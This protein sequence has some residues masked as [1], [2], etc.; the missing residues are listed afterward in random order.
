MTSTRPFKRPLVAALAVVGALALNACGGS[1][2][3]NGTDRAFVGDMVPHHSSAVD[4]AKVAQRR[5]QRPEI[6]M[7]AN[8]IIASQSQ[9]IGEMNKAK[10]ALEK[11]DVKAEKLAVP[12]DMAGMDMD[13]GSLETA[14][15]FDRAFIDMMIPH[16]QGAIRMA[17]AELD[18]GASDEL[19]TLA[20]EIIAAQTKEIKEMNA[21]RTKWFGSPSPA[22]GVPAEQ[23]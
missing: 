18:K 4:M 17:R 16:H 12:T 11:D 8:E 10:A 2:A 22:G 1:D 9:E 15:P 21:W 19:K 7:L 20:D 6:K 23:S 5:G 3:G 14:K 13:T